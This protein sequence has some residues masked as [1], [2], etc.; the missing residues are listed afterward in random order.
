MR[1]PVPPWTMLSNPSRTAVPGATISRARTS[2]G[3]CRASSSVTS[4]PAYGIHLILRETASTCVRFGSEQRFSGRTGLCGPAQRL[5]QGGRSLA[6]AND[7]VEAELGGFGQAPV[8]VGDVPELAGQ[9]QLAEGRQ[10]F[11]LGELDALRRRGQRERD[12]EVRPRLVHAH[13]AGD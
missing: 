5:P 2:L 1:A 9:P 3:S 7:G 11:V 12:R 4:S 6:R 8:R 10:R 13:A